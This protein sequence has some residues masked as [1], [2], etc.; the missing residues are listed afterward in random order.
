MKIIIILIPTTTDSR[1][2]VIVVNSIISF[3]QIVHQIGMIQFNSA[4]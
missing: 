2:M 3:Y 4:I 1:R